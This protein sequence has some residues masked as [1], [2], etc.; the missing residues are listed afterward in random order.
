MTGRPFT[1]REALNSGFL[2]RCVRTPAQLPSATD[3]MTRSLLKMSR[4]TLRMTKRSINAISSHMV[5]TAMSSW[6]DA[7]QLIAANH[8]EE[9]QEVGQRYLAQMKARAKRRKTKAK[10]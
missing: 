10:L 1:A 2:N 7:A 9:S 4:L 8:D 5:S 6:A 3:Q